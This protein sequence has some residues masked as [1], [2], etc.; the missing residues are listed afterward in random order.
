MKKENKR[1]AGRKP[2]GYDSKQI[3]VPV[4]LIPELKKRI[5]EWKLNNENCKEA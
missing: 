1:N 2:N 4:A 3:S 5:D